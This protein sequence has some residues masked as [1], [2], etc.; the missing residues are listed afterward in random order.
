MKPRIVSVMIPLLLLSSLSGCTKPSQPLPKPTT[1]SYGPNIVHLGG[2]GDVGFGESRAELTRRGLLVAQPGP[3]GPG[4]AIPAVSPVFA[5]DRLVLLWADP[6]T[7]TPEGVTVGSPVTEARAA[8]PTAR[9]LTAPPGTYRFNGLLAEQDDRAYLFL[10]DGKTV[11]KTIAGYAEHV[12]RL[13]NDG[14]GTC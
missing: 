11:R 7:R 9:E 14:F 8:Y 13:F 10:H 2:V 12:Q 1:P 3:C 6:P 5:D 4:L